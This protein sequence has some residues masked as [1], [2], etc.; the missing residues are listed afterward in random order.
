MCIDPIVL[1][2]LAGIIA[3]ICFKEVTI[4]RFLYK[5]ISFYLLA[6]IGLKGGIELCTWI[7]WTLFAQVLGVILLSALTCFITIFFLKKVSSYDPATI[8]TIAAH[9]GSVSAG[10]FAIALTLLENANINYEAYM[11]LFLALME[12]PAILIGSLMLK[13]IYQ[14]KQSTLKSVISAFSCKSL[15]T[16]LLTILLGYSV[17]P[18]LINVIEPIFFDPFKY[19]LALFL[20]EMG[21]LVGQQFQSIRTEFRTIFFHAVT[22]SLMCST[23]G[24]ALGIL[25]KLSLG[26]TIL[27]M[28]L[29]S[30][31]SYIAVPAALRHSYPQAN[32]P[33][34]LSYSLGATFPFNVFF[35]I[36]LYTYTATWIYNALGLTK[37]AITCA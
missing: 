37:I 2:F 28:V 1:F 4:P 10:T 18:Y 20:L 13:N 12:S 31:A 21:I 24:L 7:S 15:L 35:G 25:M 6:S 9:Y 29:A 19:V 3:K 33:L 22:L 36:Y 17:G 8:I 23:I 14:D 16:L 27:L 26:G 5:T 30:S 32:V 34:A 11:P